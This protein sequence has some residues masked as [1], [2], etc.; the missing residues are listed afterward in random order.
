VEGKM[1][2]QYGKQTEQ[3]ENCISKVLKGAIVKWSSVYGNVIMLKEEEYK[4]LK[5]V[6][7]SCKEK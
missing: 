5:E 7:S 4:R 3:F 1:S 2:R 6:E